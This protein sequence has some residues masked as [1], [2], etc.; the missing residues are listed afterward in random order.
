MRE[1]GVTVGIGA[2]GSMSSDNQNMFEAMRFA[3]LVN[4]V[5]FPH[6]PE[7]WIGAKEVWEMATTS[8]ARVLGMGDT[9]GAIVPAAKADLAI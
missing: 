5:R 3:A 8:G 2:D 4:K 1:R 9:I 7:R 6:Q